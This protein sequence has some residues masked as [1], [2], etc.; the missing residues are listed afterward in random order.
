MINNLYL[1]LYFY[2]SWLDNL[3]RE[4]G[5]FAYTSQIPPPSTTSSSSS[6]ALATATATTTTSN[7]I[8]N[9][10]EREDLF[11]SST[12]Y[13]T[14]GNKGIGISSNNNNNNNTNNHTNNNTKQSYRV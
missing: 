11:S 13:Q 5:E 7:P 9:F 3:R 14:N 8:Q 6:T 2:Y 10:K 1:L 12:K 4:I